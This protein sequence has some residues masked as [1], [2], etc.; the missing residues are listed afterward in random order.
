MTT[1]HRGGFFREAGI[2]LIV[3]LT[4]SLL[5]QPLM[6]GLPGSSARSNGHAKPLELILV[7]EQE[8]NVGFHDFVDLSRLGIDENSGEH[9]PVACGG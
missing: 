2:S 3:C 9:C 4:V 6:A 7:G 1:T 8:N 5:A